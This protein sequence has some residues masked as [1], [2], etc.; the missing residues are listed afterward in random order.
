VLG[1][2]AIVLARA[3]TGYDVRTA[4][5]LSTAKPAPA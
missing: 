5:R 4:R 2:M 1:A 3:L